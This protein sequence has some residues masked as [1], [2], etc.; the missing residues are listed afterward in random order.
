MGREKWGGSYF[1]WVPG[2]LDNVMT[3]LWLAEIRSGNLESGVS[4]TAT[5][6]DLHLSASGPPGS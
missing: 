5:H 6:G 3:G 4:K 2:P 1:K